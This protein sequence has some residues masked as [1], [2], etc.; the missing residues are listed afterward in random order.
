MLSN[1]TLPVLAPPAIAANTPLPYNTLALLPV[2]LIVAILPKP[3]TLAALVSNGVS[4][5]RGTDPNAA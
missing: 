3:V 1:V 5:E 2:K 4:M